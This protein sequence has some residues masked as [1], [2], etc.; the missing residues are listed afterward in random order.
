[1]YE[2]RV[3]MIEFGESDSPKPEVRKDVHL[4]GWPPLAPRLNLVCHPGTFRQK[5]YCLRRAVTIIGSRPCAHILMRSD[6]VSKI[7]AAVICD[8]SEP[9]ICD[10]ASRNGTIVRGKRVRWMVL[11]HEDDIQIGS[12]EIRVETQPLP[13]SRG[14]NFESGQFRAIT[15]GPEI[16]LVDAAGEEVFRG[17]EGAAVIGARKG[18]DILVRS[19]TCAPAMAIIMAWRNGWAV[20][21]LAPEEESWTTINGRRVLSATL[22][23]GDRLCV[24]GH[25]FAVQ[26]R[27]NVAVSMDAGMTVNGRAAADVGVSSLSARDG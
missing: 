1:L 25:S 23:P 26:I 9:I 19:E 22:T 17:R 15:A 10:L 20:Y 2:F 6:D 13:G 21:D 24:D 18:A 16:T 12:Y 11:Q 14:R 5:K 27:S 3:A 4:A 8:G 7:H